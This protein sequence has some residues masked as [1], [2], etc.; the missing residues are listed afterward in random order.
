MW[1]T[2]DESVSVE[3][4]GAGCAGSGVGR[5]SGHWGA[6]ADVVCCLWQLQKTARSVGPGRQ[7]L[8]EVI[9]IASLMPRRMSHTL[10]GHAVAKPMI[11]PICMRN[12]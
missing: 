12:Q 2:T 4:L 6:Q 5:C 8:D 10:A 7:A 11:M 3:T 9:Y 1:D